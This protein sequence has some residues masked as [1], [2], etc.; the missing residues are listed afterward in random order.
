MLIWFLLVNMDPYTGTFMCSK[1]FLP[2]SGCL[3][4][5]PA[6][7]FLAMTS[8]VLSVSFPHLYLERI[9]EMQV[10]C[11]PCLFLFFAFS[12]IT[13]TGWFPKNRHLQLFSKAHSWL[14]VKSN[15]I[16]LLCQKALQLVCRHNFGIIIDFLG[17]FLRL[18]SFFFLF[19]SF[20]FYCYSII[21]V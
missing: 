11:L 12:F 19:F 15:T 3:G 18:L 14:V 17:M 8:E 6:L 16:Y 1:I 20:K 9:T 5:I 13:I 21:V 7:L 2:R 4:W 10:H